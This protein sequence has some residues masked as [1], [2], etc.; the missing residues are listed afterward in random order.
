MQIV[1][2]SQTITFGI[3][4]MKLLVTKEFLGYL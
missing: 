4:V 1:A 2:V 3:L